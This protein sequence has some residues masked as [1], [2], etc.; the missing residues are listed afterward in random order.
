VPAAPVH[1]NARILLIEGGGEPI[2]LLVDAV[3]QVYRLRQDEVELSPS[4]G[5]D[6]PPYIV[7]IGR[8]RSLAETEEGAAKQEPELLVLLDPNMLIKG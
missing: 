7:G 5:A 8:P 1:N 6:A 2:G 4:L 3:L